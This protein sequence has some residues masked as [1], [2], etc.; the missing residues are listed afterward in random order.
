M[1]GILF[2]HLSTS[3]GC[4][5]PRKFSLNNGLDNIQGTSFSS[6]LDTKLRISS[7]SFSGFADSPF[8]M[9]GLGWTAPLLYDGLLLWLCFLKRQLVCKLGIIERDFLSIS[10]LHL[11]FCILTMFASY[12]A[13]VFNSW[14]T[15]YIY[16]YIHIYIYIYIR[17]LCCHIA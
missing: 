10:S 17:P 14:I 2:L 12:F 4:F 11:C 5:C 3:L 1:F 9:W 15:I 13:S 7:S 16:I 6:G 8:G